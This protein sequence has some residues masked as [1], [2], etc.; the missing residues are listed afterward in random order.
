MTVPERDDFDA[1]FA[2]D[3]T[4][5]PPSPPVYSDPMTGLAGGDTPI[6]F[7]DE[8]MGEG[9]VEVARPVEPDPEAVREAVQAALAEEGSGQSAAPPPKQRRARPAR[10]GSARSSPAREHQGGTASPEA[11][12]ARASR[13]AASRDAKPKRQQTAG[14]VVA[15]IVVLVIVLFNVFSGLGDWIGDLFH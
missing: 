12:S 3:G 4:Q 5:D 2:P 10:S 8:G 1:M 6:G 11:E 13:E 15:L 9:W 14:C 7:Q